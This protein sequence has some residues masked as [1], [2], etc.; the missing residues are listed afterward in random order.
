[1]SLCK[2]CDNLLTKDTTGGKLKYICPSCGTEFPSTGYD[3]LIYESNNKTFDVK[4]S[5]KTIYHYPANQKIMTPCPKCDDEI[6][7]W[8]LDH[9]QQKIY[10]CKCGYSWKKMST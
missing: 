1:M 10:G 8:E 5:G 9:L 2:K 7:A 6:V 4:K 3:T